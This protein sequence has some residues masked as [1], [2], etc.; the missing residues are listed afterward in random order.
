MRDERRRFLGWAAQVGVVALLAGC[1]GSALRP[2]KPEVSLA[3]IQ[4]S[5]GNLLEQ[6]VI[7]TLRVVNPN[8]FEIPVQGLDFTLDVNGQAL[9][10][11]VGGKPVVIPS[12]GEALIDVN[13]TTSLLSLLKQL[14]GLGKSAAGETLAYRLKGRLVTG[15]FGGFDFDQSGQLDAGKALGEPDGGRPKSEK[16]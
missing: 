5:G 16:F 11:G 7:L 15:S 6:R 2:L 1:A 13:A 3:D 4:L 14:K 12:L 8:N 10:R 9:A